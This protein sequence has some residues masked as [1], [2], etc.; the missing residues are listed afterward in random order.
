MPNYVWVAIATLLG[1]LAMLV[2]IRGRQIY[3]RLSHARKEQIRDAVAT[4]QQ[5]ECLPAWI[6]AVAADRSPLGVCPICDDFTHQIMSAWVCWDIAYVLEDCHMS[7]CSCCGKESLCFG[8]IP[9][10][11][12]QS[13]L[14]YIWGVN[15]PDAQES[16]AFLSYK[17]TLWREAIREYRIEQAEEKVIEYAAL[18]W[19]DYGIRH[20]E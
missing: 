1:V 4:P 11:Q 13:S 12:L 18:G 19:G 6:G 3:L 14:D 20:L 10:E 5:A 7:Q 9:Q 2:V 16:A 15:P 8:Y 17:L